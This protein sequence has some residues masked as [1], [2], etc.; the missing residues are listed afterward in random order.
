MS[1]PRSK[2]LGYLTKKINALKKKG[3]DKLTDNEKVEYD[4]A[5]ELMDYLSKNNESLKDNIKPLSIRN[6][7]N[8]AWYLL[9]I[10]KWAHGKDLGQTLNGKGSL[11]KF[12]LQFFVETVVLNPSNATLDIASLKQK[13]KEEK[14]ATAD[15]KMS[16][17][18]NRLEAML[19]F[20][21]MMEQRQAEFLPSQIIDQTIVTEPNPITA[22]EIKI[23]GTETDQ[24][25]NSKLGS[26]FEAYAKQWR[27]DKENNRKK[28]NQKKGKLNND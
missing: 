13:F 16:Y 10:E 22:D 21:M 17:Q 25:I 19:S 3:Y 27:I 15:R 2:E 23:N 26:A 24:N 8:D 9:Q 4:Y 28:L 14:K 6:N 7:S 12:A 20:V 5:N 18:L 11:Y 1:N